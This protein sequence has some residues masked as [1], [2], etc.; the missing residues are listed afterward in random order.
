MEAR[1]CTQCGKPLAPHARFCSYCGTSVPELDQPESHETHQASVECS[2]CEECPIQAF[3]ESKTGE[4]D[5]STS[6][7]VSSSVDSFHKDSSLPTVTLGATAR[8]FSR[9][10]MREALHIHE[11]PADVPLTA[12]PTVAFGWEPAP[13]QPT[14]PTAPIPWHT[15]IDLSG[16]D[17]S[18]GAESDWVEDLSDLAHPAHTSIPLSSSQAQVTP[19]SYARTE[20]DQLENTWSQ[21][22]PQGW[23]E[24]LEPQHT[25]VM[26]AQSWK[27]YASQR[28]NTGVMDPLSMPHAQEAYYHGPTVYSS[29]KTAHQRGLTLK[30]T[31]IVGLI[32]ALFGLIYVIQFNPYFFDNLRFAFSNWLSDQG[33]NILNGFI[34]GVRNIIDSIAFRV[35]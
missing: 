35:R 11:E 29:E 1:F 18:V 17:V 7:E 27:D 2:D 23:T 3:E 31:L 26:P 34:E 25:E 15:D 10:D 30:I 14:G 22:R 12:Q 19:P 9:P 21:D 28:G 8:A 33:K 6:F 20:P 16:F 13:L 32:L 4:P 5:P 24:G